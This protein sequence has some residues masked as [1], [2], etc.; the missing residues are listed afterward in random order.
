MNM[1][2]M[3]MLEQSAH[4]IDLVRETLSG[5]PLQFDYTV[6]R[7]REEYITKLSSSN[8]DVILCTGQLPQFD[9]LQ[10]LKARNEKNITTP[11]ILVT[12]AEYEQQAIALIKEGVDD[13][14][15]KDRMQRLPVAIEKA[16]RNQR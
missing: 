8:F 3:L 12:A 4:D 13:Y 5:S 1:I 14:I 2:R 6:A 7:S 10:A 15:I 16:I 11:F 9:A